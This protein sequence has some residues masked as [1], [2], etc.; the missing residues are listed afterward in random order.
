MS[1]MIH[2][3]GIY[4]GSKE[5]TKMYLCK[6]ETCLILNMK[7]SKLSS[8]F[9]T[10]LYKLVVHNRFA[11]WCINFH[12]LKTVLQFC[13]TL[14][15]HCLCVISPCVLRALV[16][17]L[18]ILQTCHCPADLQQKSH[19]IWLSQGSSG[20]QTLQSK[21]NEGLCLVLELIATADA[22]KEDLHLLFLS[23]E[24]SEDPFH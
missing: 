7:Q 1:W 18:Q 9:L 2:G 22:Q 3:R 4:K 21:P 8:L 17:H 12:V 15:L 6:A 20:P 13:I 10:M 16:H 24:V 11:S 23:M 14:I 5:P 19:I